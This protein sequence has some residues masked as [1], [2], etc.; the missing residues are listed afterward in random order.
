MI[1]IRELRAADDDWVVHRHG[2]VYREEFSWNS[3]FEELVST[4]VSDYH[5]NFKPGR[6][7]AWIAEVDGVPAGCVFCCERS[8]DTAQLR[9]LLVD[10]SARGLRLGARLVDQCIDHARAVGYRS[11]VLWTNDVLLAAR[12]IYTAAGFELVSQEPHR[13]FGHDLVGQIW[14]LG[15]QS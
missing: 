3:E 1:N 8:A 7:N 10:P 6:E 2:A 4:I 5:A 9:I 15:L 11:I 14:E 13:S 12:K